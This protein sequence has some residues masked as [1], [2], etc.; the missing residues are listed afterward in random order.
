MKQ[1]TL[2][3]LLKPESDEILLAMKKRGFGAGKL[4]GVGGK[5]EPDEIIEASAVREA[6]EEIGVQILP[7]NLKKVA[8]IKFS[9]DQKPDWSIHCH[10][11]LATEWKGEPMETE[12]MAPTWFKVAEIPYD[13][14]WIDDKHWLPLVLE[15]KNIEASF[16]FNNDGSAILTQSV[17][18][19]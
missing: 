16:G 1:N 9:F 8:E 11:F 13:Q 12:E 5:V 7:E 15:G 14:M 10:V 17:K 6:H 4:N 19:I 2:L 3:F 18:V